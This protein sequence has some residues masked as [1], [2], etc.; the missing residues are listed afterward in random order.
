MAMDDLKL[1][2]DDISI[3]HL[4]VPICEACEDKPASRVLYLDRHGGEVVEVRM[5]KH[6]CLVEVA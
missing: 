2:Q 3:E 4:E 6:D 5:D 1:C